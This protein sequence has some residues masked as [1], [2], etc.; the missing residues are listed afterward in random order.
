MPFFM[1]FFLT[2]YRQLLYKTKSP[3]VFCHNDLQ[4]GNI[5]IVDE[6]L[7]NGFRKDLNFLSKLVFVDFEY[8]SYNF[9]FDF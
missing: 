3:I 9:R 4:E 2:I 5:L 1:K 7:K 6:S 8:A